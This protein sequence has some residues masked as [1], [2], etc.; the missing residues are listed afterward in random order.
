[1]YA[2][3]E[4]GGKQ[5]RVSEGDRIRVERLPAGEGNEV[6]FD[7]VLLVGDGDSTQVGTPY[8][9]GGAVSALVRAQG[10]GEKLHVIKFKRRTRYRRRQGHRQAYTELEIKGISAGEGAKQ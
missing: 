1:M 4:T 3:F 8:L 6:R 7:K 10:R 9:E 5:Y 2:V